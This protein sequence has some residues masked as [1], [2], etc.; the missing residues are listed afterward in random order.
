[1]SSN[2]VRPKGSS[3]KGG[4]VALSAIES[5]G[6]FTATLKLPWTPGQSVNSPHNVVCGKT[7]RLQRR[8]LENGQPEIF[9]LDDA[10]NTG[11]RL[12]ARQSR[13]AGSERSRERDDDCWEVDVEGQ[14]DI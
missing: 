2:L 14:S 6:Q 1:M 4:V 8:W 13:G 11:V 10:E 5:F 3:E 9:W 12:R 7:I